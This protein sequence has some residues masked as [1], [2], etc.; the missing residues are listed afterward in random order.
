MSLPQLVSPEFTTEIPSTKQKIKFRPFLVK[1]EKILLM[2][3]ESGEPSDI[4]N[5]IESILTNCILDS[6]DVK[7]LAVFDL[8]FLFLQLRGKSVGEEIEL[9]LKHVKKTDCKHVTPFKINLDAIK[10]N[11]NIS[12][13]KVMLDGKIGVK[14]RYPTFHMLQKLQGTEQNNTD[15]LFKTLALMIEYVYDK[16]QVYNEFT[17]TEME[18]WISQLNQTQFQKITSFFENMPKLKQKIEWTCTKCSEKDSIELE[19]LQSFFT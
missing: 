14:L 4:Q 5:A 19:G 6:I 15:S 16:E 1:E 17:D 3:L 13:G 9:L 11:G 7:S 8:E 2:A 10:V 18:T 12:D